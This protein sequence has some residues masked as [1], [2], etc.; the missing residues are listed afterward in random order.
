MIS[1][2][3]RFP[4]IIGDFKELSAKFAISKMK[5]ELSKNYRYKRIT[6]CT[7]LG[8]GLTI[9]PELTSVGICELQLTRLQ[10]KVDI[11]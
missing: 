11:R 9:M 7:P 5:G 8:L 6:Y 3:K 4:Q 1:I 2:G 10:L